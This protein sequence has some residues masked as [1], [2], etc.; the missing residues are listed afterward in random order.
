[1][2][3]SEIDSATYWKNPFLSLM[4]RPQAIP[5]IVRNIDQ[6]AFD[7][8]ESRAAIR[9]KFKFAEIEVQRDKDLGVNDQT[10]FT[11]SHLGEMLTYDDNV[12]GYDLNSA[13]FNED[14]R[15]RLEKMKVTISSKI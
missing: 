9:N 1:M 2:E 8:N 12:L 11:Y 4:T 3:T 5:F 13:N 15:I 14:L 10:Y 7:V 6:A